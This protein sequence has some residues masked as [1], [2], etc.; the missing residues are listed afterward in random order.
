MIALWLAVSGGPVAPM[1]HHH[2]TLAIWTAFLLGQAFH[3]LL[4]YLAVIRSK[5]NAVGTLRQFVAVKGYD[6]LYRFLILLTLFWL[7][8]EAPPTGV[9]FI[10]KHSPDFVGE[11][12][13]IEP[14][15]ALAWALGLVGDVVVDKITAALGMQSVIPPAAV[16]SPPPN[17]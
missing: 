10:A 4:I 16:P 13:T 14:F 11:L 5:T 15:P 7:W 3:V 1:L 9:A 2:R 8:K 17:P 12:L 6:I